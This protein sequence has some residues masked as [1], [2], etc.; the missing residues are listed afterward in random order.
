MRVSESEEKQTKSKAS[1]LQTLNFKVPRAFKKS[2]KLYAVEHGISMIELL[3][4][5]F[6]LSRKNRKS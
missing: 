5:G 3:R 6:E 2:F 4:E 1:D